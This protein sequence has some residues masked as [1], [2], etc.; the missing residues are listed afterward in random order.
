MLTKHQVLTI[1]RMLVFGFNFDEIATMVG[2]APSIVAQAEKRKQC[3]QDLDER[4][5]PINTLVPP[6]RQRKCRI[7]SE[8]RIQRRQHTT[9]HL[10]IGV[11]RFVFELRSAPETKPCHLQQIKIV[12]GDETVWIG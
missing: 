10:K 4:L 6:K 8:T 2:V 12:N 3:C 11:E 9:P 1:K 5:Q 7:R